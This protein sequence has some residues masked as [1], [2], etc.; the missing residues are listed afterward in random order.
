MSPNVLTQD[1]VEIPNDA[2]LQAMRELDDGD[3]VTVSNMDDYRKVVY[4]D[5]ADGCAR[6]ELHP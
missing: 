4:G 2:T 6:K 5:A 3:C 1:G